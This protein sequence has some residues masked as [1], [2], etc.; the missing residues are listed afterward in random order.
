NYLLLPSSVER[1]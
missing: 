1:S